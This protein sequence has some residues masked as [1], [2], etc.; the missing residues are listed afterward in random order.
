[1]AV[2]LPEPEKPVITTIRTKRTLSQKQK[3][4]FNRMGSN[5]RQLAAG[6]FTD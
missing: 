2:L 4:R 6:S 5:P 1:M 3:N